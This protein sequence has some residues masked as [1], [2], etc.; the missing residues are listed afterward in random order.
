MTPDTFFSRKRVADDLEHYPQWR[1]LL[2][3]LGECEVKHGARIGVVNFYSDEIGNSQIPKKLQVFKEV[4]PSRDGA[5]L[6]LASSYLWELS[7]RL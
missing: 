5:Q 6:Q 7:P 3:E 2:H 4:A 1:S